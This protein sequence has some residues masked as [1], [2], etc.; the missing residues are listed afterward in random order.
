MPELEP[1]PVFAERVNARAVFQDVIATEEDNLRDL[2]TFPLR[3]ANKALAFARPLRNL[4]AG[5]AGLPA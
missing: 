2:Q 4:C 1:H 5:A 3:S